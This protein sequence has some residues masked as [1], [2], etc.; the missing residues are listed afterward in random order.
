MRPMLSGQ[1]NMQMG[2]SGPAP[3]PFGGVPSFRPPGMPMGPP[4]GPARPPGPDLDALLSKQTVQG[5][6]RTER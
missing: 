2:M 5:R 1:H 4:T 6:A 3:G